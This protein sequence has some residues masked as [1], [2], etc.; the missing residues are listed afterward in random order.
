[1]KTRSFRFCF[2][3]AAVA[4]LISGC[5]QKEA[6]VA[7]APTPQAALSLRISAEPALES[8][9]RERAEAF[10]K[11]QPKLA[12][13]R[14]V[15]IELTPRAGV[16][17]A[18][19]IASGRLR[20]DGWLAPASWLAEYANQQVKNL[21]APVSDCR[22]LF[23]T[24]L[25]AVTRKALAEQLRN[26]NG[27]VAWAALLRQDQT[28][29]PGEETQLRPALRLS[30]QS[31]T[32]SAAGMAALFQFAYAAALLPEGSVIT[33]DL[34]QDPLYQQRLSNLIHTAFDTRS[35]ALQLLADLAR[36][37]DT[38][39]EVVITSEQLYKSFTAKQP[40]LLEASY[41]AEHTAWLDH[42]LCRSKAD[43]VSPDRQAAFRLFA[44]FLEDASSQKAALAQGFRAPAGG[45]TSVLSGL[46]P[47]S[48]MPSPDAVLIGKLL[49]LWASAPRE[50]LVILVFDASPLFTGRMFQL[51]KYYLAELIK[52]ATPTLSWSLITVAGAPTIWLEPTQ[53]QTRAAAAVNE[54]RFSGSS[55][56]P[57]ALIKALELA[58]NSKVWHK[59]NI[60][61]LT[62]AV[63]LNISGSNVLAS[64]TAAA[65]FA[66]NVNLSAYHVGGGS[67][68]ISKVSELIK[69]YYGTIQLGTL[70]KIQDF[71]KYAGEQF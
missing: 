17:A 61:V 6:Q 4:A 14:L 37:A 24:P 8:F 65:A 3:I 64:K 2:L 27:E 56:L 47:Q 46:L 71:L 58:Q 18:T 41:F 60:I 12:D 57:E 44:A 53:D 63:S 32:S 42:V 22:P 20:I 16:T 52:A 48:S 59:V 54:L 5:D 33:P 69:G 68:E 40:N 62:S 1:M 34:A 10:G 31:P 66:A 28:A 9:I 21:G 35:D 55:A 7:S 13:G 49:D 36:R 29:R 70:D 38:T 23:R 50:G 19:E 26:Q 30:Y 51:A 45:A 15:Q 39:P 25:V 67:V 11:T 43:W